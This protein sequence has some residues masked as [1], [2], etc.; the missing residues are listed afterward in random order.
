MPAAGV[1]LDCFVPDQVSQRLNATS[2]A[3]RS[4]SI[5]TEARAYVDRQKVAISAASG[6]V[7]VQK[8]HAY[9]SGSGITDAVAAD[10]KLAAF[11]IRNTMRG[12][13]RSVISTLSPTSRIRLGMSITDSGSVQ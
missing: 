12:S 3:P 8:R 4:T 13:T 7:A 9:R 10:D 11:S 1:G 2:A 6:L 5:G